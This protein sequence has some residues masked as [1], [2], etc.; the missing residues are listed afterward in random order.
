MTLFR[1]SVSQLTATQQDSL[2]RAVSRQRLSVL[3]KEV[4]YGGDVRRLVTAI[5]EFCQMETY[6]PNAPYA[7]GVTGVGISESDVTRLR[8]AAESPNQTPLQ[9]VSR[10]LAS[11]IANNVLEVRPNVNVKGGLWTVFFP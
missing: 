1:G 9:R 5:G 2:L 11:A 10:V 3:P 8:E 7:P 4:P 6:R